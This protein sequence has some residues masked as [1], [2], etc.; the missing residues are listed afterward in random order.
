M[1]L[2]AFDG[3][4]LVGTAGSGSFAMTTPGGV[5]VDT[6]GLTIVAVLPA[7][8]RRGILR[9]PMRRH[10]DEVR[11]RQIRS[12]RAPWCPEVFWSPE[13][14]RENTRKRRKKSGG[15]LRRS[16]CALRECRWVDG[17]S[18]PGPTG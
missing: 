7:H 9:D 14:A 15:L 3:G 4:E 1:R 16:S 6:E 13:R 2:A 11:A 10:L 12:A 8:R 18:N 17:D 5:A